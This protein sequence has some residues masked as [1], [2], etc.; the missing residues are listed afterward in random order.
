MTS[1]HDSV[2]IKHSNGK[3][4]SSGKN[5]GTFLGTFLTIKGCVAEEK[6]GAEGNDVTIGKGLLCDF[7]KVDRFAA[8][9]SQGATF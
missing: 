5:L 7:Y 1:S 9:V 4:K 2:H 6:Y 8:A 3:S